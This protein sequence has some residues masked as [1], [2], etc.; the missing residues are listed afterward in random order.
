[1]ALKSTLDTAT[2]AE[3]I[4]PWLTATLGASPPV[5][6]HDVEVP[7][8]TGMSSETVLFNAS[9]QTDQAH[10]ERGFVVRMRPQD[11][12]ILP[13]YDLGREARFM[14]AVG[15]HTDVPVPAVVAHEKS[16]AVLGEEFILM[17][18]HYG[19][20][21]SDDPPFVT[22]GW[23]VELTPQQRAS[24]YDNALQAIAAIH[25]IDVSRTRLHNPAESGPGSSSLEGQLDYWWSYYE[26]AA[27]SRPVPTF[28]RAIERLIARRPADDAPAVVSWG[29]PRFANM[30]FGDHEEITGILD[31][32]LAGTGRPELDVGWWF[33]VERMYSEGFGIPVLSGFPERA[34]AVARYEQL[35][36]YRV[37]DLDWFEAFAALRAGLMFM[38]IGYQLIDLGV[39]PPD[40]DLPYNNP[41]SQTLSRLLG[42]PAPTG[43]SG[44][45]TG[46]R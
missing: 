15:E 5:N 30:M 9:W 10:C 43:Q 42:L 16:G 2:F 26:W 25:R 31:W 39:M 27:R 29:D 40:A 35:S 36:G 3:K 12:G 34:A 23:V 32:E 17:Q 14:Q 18:R 45:L 7:F 13:V 44:W 33:F 37:R 20:I 41:C 21:P 46:N 6:V 24:M 19:R 1:M 4:Q 38:R 11:G 22:T 8:A 28:E